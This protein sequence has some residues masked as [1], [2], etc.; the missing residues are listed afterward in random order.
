MKELHT[1]MFEYV[2]TDGEEVMPDESKGLT[3]D[4]MI[5]NYEKNIIKYA[6]EKYGS[7]RKAAKAL[8]ISQ[9]QMVRKKN[10]YSI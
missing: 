1:D 9:T 5:N 8:G 3:L 7:S 2:N 6:Y 4:I 10:K